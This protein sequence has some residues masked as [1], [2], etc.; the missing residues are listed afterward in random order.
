MISA[1]FLSVVIANTLLAFIVYKNNPRSATNVIFSLLS[2]SIIAWLITTYVS[3]SPQYLSS[4]LFWIRLSLFFAVPQAILFFLLAHTLPSKN[5]LIKNWVLSLIA[6]TGLMVALLT[7]SPFVFS[8]VE[9]VN[10]SPKPIPGPLI[11][12]FA[13]YVATL[14]VLAI[15][16]LFKKIK[17]STGVEKQQIIFVTFGILLMIGLI[18]ITILIPLIVIRSNVFVAYEPIYTLIFL[19]MTAY[20]IIRHRFLDIRVLVARTTSYSLLLFSL[21][22][23]YTGAIFTLSE[24]APSGLN[25]SYIYMLLALVVAFSFDPLKVFLEKATDKVFF[26]GRYDT[27]ELLSEL[28]HIMASEINIQ[29]LSTKLLKKLNSDIRL[30]KGA[31][32]LV[33]KDSTIGVE[34]VGF[35][36]EIPLIDKKLTNLAYGK[37]QLYIFEE[38]TDEKMKN[39]FRKLDITAAIPLEVKDKPIGLLVLGP[40][41]SGEIYSNQDIEVLEILAPQAAVALQNAQSYRAIQEFSRTLE[42]KV[43][44]R[45]K[46]LKETQ[47][48]ELAKAKELLKLKDEF[49]FIATHDLRTPVTA[50]R[51][52]VELIQESKP[53]FTYEVKD[54]FESIMNASGRLNQLV[55]DLLEVARSE[56]GTIKVEVEPVSIVEIIEK[57]ITEVTPSAHKKKVTL[58]TDLDNKVKTVMGDKDKLAEV[59][60]NLLSNAVKFSRQKGVVK[61]TTQKSKGNLQVEVIDNGY[62]IPK[63]KQ[64]KVFQKFFQARTDE[65]KEVPGTGLGLFVVRMLIEKM[66]GKVSFTSEERKGTTFTFTLPL[67]KGKKPPAKDSTTKKQKES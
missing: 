59:I 51:G 1:I 39:L 50:I 13:L 12:V 31:F 54:K 15:Y 46:E 43:E 19:G 38:L 6:A 11:I 8:G 44:E 57:V 26:K 5:I 3:L 16:T 23:I 7:L 21:I 18:I 41:A 45:T 60:E 24:F 55:T 48:R 25:R 28:T 17:R 30:T 14:S 29:R 56:S 40:K 20:A 35:D 65:T 64:K 61:V 9:I 36:Q 62:G 53:K 67:A 32:I 2:F 27:E 63:D 52:F 66:K 34:S 42:H 4:S 33:D 58:K 49:V 37:N 47:V 10:N 22:G